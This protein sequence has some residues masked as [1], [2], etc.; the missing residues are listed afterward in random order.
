MNNINE[1]L[2]KISDQTLMILDDDDVFR[3]RLIT[4]M[5]R[6]GFDAYGASSVKEA[7]LLLREKSPKYA[8]I[9]LRLNDGNGLEIVSILSGSRSDSKIV[10]PVSYTH[11]TLPTRLP[12]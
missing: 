4:A 12:V 3:N 5:K 10:M 9:D 7:K 8:V 1:G 6:K 11:L 2:T